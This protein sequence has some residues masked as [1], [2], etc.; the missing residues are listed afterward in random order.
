MLTSTESWELQPTAGDVLKGAICASEE[1]PPNNRLQSSATG[2]ML[3]RR[4][5]AAAVGSE[6]ARDRLSGWRGFN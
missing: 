1:E 3:S 4:A 6:I 5:E 2:A